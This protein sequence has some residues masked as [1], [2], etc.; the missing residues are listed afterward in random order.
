MTPAIKQPQK[1]KVPHTLHGY[2]H[3]QSAESYGLEAAQ[4]LGLAPE[5]VFKT[6]VVRTNDN[7][8]VVGI[9]PVSNTLNLKAI[10]S[11]VGSKKATMA[12]KTQVQ[13]MSGYVIGGVSPLGQKKRL[14]TVIDN[15]AFDHKTIYVSA[16]KRGL[17]V[18]LSPADLK[19]LCNATCAT[20]TA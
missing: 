2:D 5:Q 8:F 13:S 17:D 1:H 11:V 18:E 10:A 9:V 6:L 7:T 16:G 3:D 14:K 19:A 20:I 15:S 4:K 12:D